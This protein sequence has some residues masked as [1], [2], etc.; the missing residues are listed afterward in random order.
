MQAM[1]ISILSI[2]LM[3]GT[4]HFRINGWSSSPKHSEGRFE[5]TYSGT[6]YVLL[7]ST[8]A[9][10][11]TGRQDRWAVCLPIWIAFQ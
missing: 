6:L 10:P 8:P 4:R 1:S 9:L 11:C 5:T 3:L 7:V 2:R